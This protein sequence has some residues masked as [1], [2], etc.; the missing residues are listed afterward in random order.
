MINFSQQT[1]QALFKC[2]HMQT[3]IIPWKMMGNG[4]A[5]GYKHNTNIN[6]CLPICSK[7]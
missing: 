5:M 6:I 1:L 4:N 3:Q 2:T 7:Q